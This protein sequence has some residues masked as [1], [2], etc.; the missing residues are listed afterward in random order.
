MLPARLIRRG[1]VP[2]MRRVPLMV[3][4]SVLIVVHE[5]GVAVIVAVSE[6]VRERPRVGARPGN[7]EVLSGV[8]APGHLSVTCRGAGLPVGVVL[9]AA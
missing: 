2:R 5:H 3:R 1:E 8:T 4:T 6:A 7:I 9:A